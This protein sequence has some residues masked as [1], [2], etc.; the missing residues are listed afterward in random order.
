MD[1][2]ARREHAF[3]ELV[4]K[5]SRKFTKDGSPRESLDAVIIEQVKILAADN[6]QSD[7]RYIESFINGRKSQGKGPL[8]IRQE[9]EYKGISA[10]LI[11]DFLAEDD[12]L[13]QLLAEEVYRK[14]FASSPINDYQDKSKRLRFMQY[15]GFSYEH[16]QFVIK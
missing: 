8:R 5:L 7:E 14:K 11:A 6:L 15:R 10:E 1:Y 16:I 12:P 2:L 13:W 9:L 3:Y 4:G